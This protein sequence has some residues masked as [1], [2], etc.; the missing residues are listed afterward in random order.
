M[1]TGIVILSRY[2]SSRLPGKALRIMLG[3]TVL[4]YIVERL[5]QV[6]PLENIVLA[7]SE[8][9]SDDPIEA[10]AKAAGVKCYRGSLENVAQRFHDAAAAQGWEYATRINGDNI[11]ADTDVLRDMIALAET[12]Q[13][14]FVSNVKGRTF[15]KGMSVEIVRLKHYADLLPTIYA[16]PQYREHVTLYLYEHDAGQTYYYY[17]NDALPEASGI[18]LAL[19]TQEDWDR[20]LHIM[21]Q[22]TAPHWT[23][24]MKDIL[25][26][27]NET[28]HA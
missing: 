21:Q 18:Q 26:I 15:P 6:V 28:N 25:T 10:F 9:A 3:K 11:F 2:S 22:F 17:M 1:R 7:T 8:E 23:Y 5:L 14:D 24:N 4:T 13:Y 27:I 19:D 20:T 16:S 12:G